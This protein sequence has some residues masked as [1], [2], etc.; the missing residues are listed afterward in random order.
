MPS[1]NQETYPTV[2]QRVVLLIIIAY[3]AIGALLGGALLILAP[4]GSYMKMPVEMMHGFFQ[5]F[6]IPGIILL[7]LGILNSFAF[8]GVLLKKRYDWILAG[9][10]LGGLFIW[11][12]VEIIVLQELHWLHIM[13]G[14][15]VLLGWIMAI[16]V[17]ASRFPNEKAELFL[18]KCGIVSSVWYTAIN[19]IVPFFYSGYSA[20]TFTVS[21]LSAIGSPTRI[22]WVLLCLFYSLTFAAFGWG[23]LIS[24]RGQTYLRVVGVL[25]LIFSIFGL[26]WPPMNMRGHEMEVTD[27]LHI[28]WAACT[29]IFMWLFMGYGAAALS[30][31][32]RIFTLV[33]IALH[34]LFGILTSFES[35]HIISNEP[36]PLIGLWE[37]INIGIFM[38]WVIVFAVEL[39][40]SKTYL[41][42]S[43][44]QNTA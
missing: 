26:Y 11:F 1:A 38:I 10:G 34:I 35:P 29:N 41:R 24:F 7:G 6:K 14:I 27:I 36:T 12:I 2:W 4:D 28:T 22:M 40:K 31:H 43:P 25:I 19:I 32:F 8:W 3:E 23:V 17:I 18:L 33:S 21:E 13:W 20:V 5:D 39:L 16:P 30:R 42:H 44:T 15:P 9:L 37:R